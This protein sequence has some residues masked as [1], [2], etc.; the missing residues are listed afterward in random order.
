MSLVQKLEKLRNKTHR[1]LNHSI[2]EGITSETRWRLKKIVELFEQSMIIEL[3]GRI[4]APDT[5][6]AEGRLHRDVETND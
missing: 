4:Q 6:L 5:C 1:I 2:Q 3:G